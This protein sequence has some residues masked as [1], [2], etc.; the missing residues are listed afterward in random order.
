MGQR[1]QDYV[2]DSA[3]SYSIHNLRQSS[4]TPTRGDDSQS[5]MEAPPTVRRVRYP[6]WL[7]SNARKRYLLNILNLHL[8][9]ALMIC[10][11]TILLF[12]AQ[13]R[14]LFVPKNGDLAVDVVFL[15]VFCFFWIDTILRMD[16]ESN[17]FHLYLL[18]FLG[19]SSGPRISKSNS[20]PLEIHP[21][22]GYCF[23]RPFHIG[24][25][26]FWCDVVS[27]LALLRE[28]TLVDPEGMFDEARIHINL[29]DFGMPLH[30]SKTISM[31]RHR[32][33]TTNS[34]ATRIMVFFFLL[35]PWPRSCQ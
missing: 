23:G 11:T 5:K 30:V 15:V 12:G 6:L 4:T 16:C 25:F 14:D 10:F 8:W 3:Q 2:S 32:T 29:D 24:S 18:S 35:G 28:I 17:Y 33:P 31:S 9:K 7:D 27:N 26:L 19:Y 1:N 13:I 22:V 34:P 21:S 20:E